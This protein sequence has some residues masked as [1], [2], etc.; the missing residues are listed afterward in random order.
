MLCPRPTTSSWMRSQMRP[1]LRALLA[2]VLTAG[3]IVAV[4]A[5]IHYAEPA[6][7]T[8]ATPAGTATWRGLV[9]G[10]HPE[11]SLEGRQIVLLRTPAVADRLARVR[12][13]T[14]ADERRW[15]A[16]AY[17][18]QQQVLTALARRGLGV[19]PDYTYA[20]VV[21]GFAATL[22]PRAVALLESLPEV[23]G[24]Y[25]VRAAFPAATETAA[26]GAAALPSSLPG[27]DGTGLTIALLDTGV[28]RTHPSLRRRV[29]AA[30]ARGGPAGTAQPQPNPQ[31]P[32]EVERHGTQIAG[33][34]V[35]SGGGEAPRGVA[36]GA[37]VLP[38]R[39][40]GWQPD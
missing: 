2:V 18:A 34:L 33:L 40:A 36:P 35:G 22:D 27:D 8:R 3:L 31:D 15:T 7:T 9:G 28:G 20:R 12:Y 30:T 39:V 5:G 11:V 29:E 26:A 13:A 1:E 21:D 6:A 19:R 23:A 17:A 38:I 25:P 4:I 32:D 24:V 37:T 10:G 14:E 16:Q